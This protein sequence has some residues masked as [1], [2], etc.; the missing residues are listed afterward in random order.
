MEPVLEGVELLASLLFED[1]QLPVEHVAALRELHLGEVAPQ[2]L[3]ASRL[4]VDVVATDEDDRAE[5][6]VLRLVDPVLALRQD[7]PRERELRLDRRLQR[8]GHGAILMRT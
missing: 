4:H 1:D 7:L 6:V 3:A 8:E 2:R 5:A